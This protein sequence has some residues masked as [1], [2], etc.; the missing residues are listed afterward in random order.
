MAT[1]KVKS[2]EEKYQSLSEIDHILLR[3][4][5]YVGSIKN[6]TSNRFIYNSDDAQMVM[7]EVE[8]VPAILKII[9]EIISNSCDEFRR[10]SNMGLTEITVKIDNSGE[11]IIRDN[12]GIPVAMH[13]TAKMYVPEFI[14]SCLRVSSNY[15]DS[16]NRDV[17]GLNG[18]G[19]TLTAIFSEYFSVYTADKKKSY[20]RSWENNLKKK[21]NDE[22]IKSCKDHFT[23]LHFRIDFSKFE[24]VTELSDDFIN[25][26]EKRCIDA[27]AANTGLTVKFEHL[28]DS[29]TVRSSEWYFSKFEQYIDLYGSYIDINTGISFSDKQKSVWIFPDSN[30]NIGFVNGAECSK[31]THI[32]AVHNEVNNA[33]SSYIN[34]KKKIDV[35]PRNI[36]DKYSS[37][38]ILHVDNPTFD[39]QTKDTLTTPVNKFEA[40]NPDYKFTVPKKF[41]DDVCKSDIVDTVVDWFKQKQEVEDQKTL[42][43]LNKEAKKKI[44]RNDKFIDANSKKREDRE[45]WIFEGDSA[46]AG[47]RKARDPQRQAAYMLRGV[48][49]N[50]IDATP[51]KVMANKELSDLVSIIGLQW[52]VVN[53]KEDLNFNRIVLAADSDFDGNKI[54]SILLLF[55]NKFPELFDYGIVMKSISP[56]MI[57]SKKGCEDIKIYTYKE[58]KE[59]EKSLKGYV[60]KYAKGLGS[61]DDAQYKEMIQTPTFVMFDKDELAD[62]TFKKWFGKKDVRTRRS[63]LDVE[64]K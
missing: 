34:T 15:D 43:K 32:K 38:C 62:M 8:Y 37:F 21:N 57:A 11:I 40:N 44:S 5:M 22:K 4:G 20:F 26:I 18:L 2:I 63:D 17:I 12:G 10:T 47:F 52:G 14:F 56:I 23:E 3:S 42:R 30:I 46:Q 60:I 41:L 28:R 54:C 39:S 33:V 45:L 36:D 19:S 7:K 58:Y 25:I 51:S 1:S 50:T 35:Q 64:V 61:L 27:A 59:K 31:G 55:F 16:E 6:E 48:T 24:D 53:K 29:V 49:L 13:K 9:D